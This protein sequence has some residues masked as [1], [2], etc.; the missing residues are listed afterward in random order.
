LS[1]GKKDI[2]NNIFSEA[3][4]SKSDAKN[5][6]ESFLGFIKNNRSR[7]IK[8]SN[9]GTFSNHKSPRRIGRNPKTKQEFIIP[10][11]EKLIFKASSVV[12]NI[13]N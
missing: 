4:L 7:N 13:L 2:V 1:L 5:F 3:F 8:I 10:K 9:F 11:R 6:L 12:R